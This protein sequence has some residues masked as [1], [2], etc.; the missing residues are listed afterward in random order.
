MD[1]D[2]TRER[3]IARQPS[4]MRRLLVVDETDFAVWRGVAQCACAARRLGQTEAAVQPR[5]PRTKVCG[6]R[7]IS[8]ALS[9][10]AGVR[11]S[12]EGLD[13]CPRS[14]LHKGCRDRFG[15][16]ARADAAQPAGGAAAAR[17]LD[18]P[19]RLSS[20]S[21]PRRAPEVAARVQ[22]GIR[23]RDNGR[24]TWPSPDFFGGPTPKMNE[25]GLH[26]ASAD[27]T[28]AVSSIFVNGPARNRG[29][30]SAVA[31]LGRFFGFGTSRGC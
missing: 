4:R 19:R 6:R 18:T 17:R 22:D 16:R 1:A 29:Q 25:T 28:F 12:F 10:C 23:A 13:G 9:R 8:F 31:S 21:P 14:H 30:F 20:R 3:R 15:R 7:F 27:R 24:S 2:V 11:R 26:S 5:K